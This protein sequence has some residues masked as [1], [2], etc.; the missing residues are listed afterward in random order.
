MPEESQSR[1]YIR[2]HSAPASLFPSYP[3]QAMERDLSA[4]QKRCPG[5]KNGLRSF[6]HVLALA[7]DG[8]V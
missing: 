3:L 5:G 8:G 2:P 4:C 1:I 6:N 7:V